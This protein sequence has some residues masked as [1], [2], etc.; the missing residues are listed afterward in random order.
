MNV[1][2]IIPLTYDSPLRIPLFDFLRSKNYT[3]GNGDSINLD[4]NGIQNIQRLIIFVNRPWIRYSNKEK[5]GNTLQVESGFNYF[6]Q[7]PSIEKISSL[8]NVL[9]SLNKN[10]TQYTLYD[11]IREHYNNLCYL[12][13]L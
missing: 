2:L 9:S 11:F 8:L 5:Y 4:S 7:E 12:R 3:W 13:K 1:R 6:V 10:E